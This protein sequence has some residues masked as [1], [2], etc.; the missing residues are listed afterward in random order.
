[1]QNERECSPSGQRAIVLYIVRSCVVCVCVCAVEPSWAELRWWQCLLARSSFTLSSTRSHSL[2][3][4][5]A[6]SHVSLFTALALFFCFHDSIRS[7]ILNCLWES[8]ACVRVCASRSTSIHISESSVAFFA[9]WFVLVLNQFTKSDNQWNHKQ[10][11]IEQQQH[12]N[13]YDRFMY[14]CICCVYVF[15]LFRERLSY[16]QR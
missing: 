14:V 2:L 10:E 6:H 3:W 16:I 7:I 4:P 8:V 1:M 12:M 9:F 5:L 11:E 13:K 15:F